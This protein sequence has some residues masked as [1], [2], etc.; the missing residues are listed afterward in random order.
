M[1]SSFR[2]TSRVHA[3]IALVAAYLLCILAPHA[4][5]AL[6]NGSAAMHCLIELSDLSHVHQNAAVPMTH[7]HADGMAHEHHGVSMQTAA[8]E[9]G[10]GHQN[11][12]G[13]A[14]D[15][16]CCGVFCI[17][18]LNHDGVIALPAP[19]PPVLAKAEPEA[20]GVSRDPDRIDEPPIG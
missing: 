19:P 2:R 14:P 10:D 8:Q 4:A 11:G 13:K 20:E 1:F 12:H 18:A 9:H 3:T 16:S 6:S 5:L 17:T 7:G 15:G